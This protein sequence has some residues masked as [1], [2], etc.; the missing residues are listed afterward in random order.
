MNARHEFVMRA[1]EPDANL[2][3]LCRAAGISRKTAYKW[4]LRFRERGMVGLE[5]MSRRPRGSSLRATGEVVMQVLELRGAHPRWGPKKLRVVIARGLAVEDVPS[6]RTIAR[7]LERAGEVRARRRPPT[8]N[9]ASKDAP[10]V[11]ANAPNA[12]WTVDFKG[13]WNAKDGAKCEP[14]TVR[15]AFSRYVLKAK[16][17]TQTGTEPVRAEFTELFERR[18]TPLAIQVDNGPPFGSTQARCG[19]TTLSAWWVA[20]GIR[21]I[22]GRPAHPQDNGAHE[23]MHLDMRYEVED[24][25]ADNLERQQA[26][27]DKW[28][29]EFN[30]VRP[31]EAI[32]LK[33]PS[34]LY[35]SSPRRY[36]GPRK[37]RYPTTMCTRKVTESGRV[38]Y[39]GKLL[40]IGQGFRGYEIGMESLDDPTIVRV[41]FYE[42][43]LGVFQLPV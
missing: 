31:H 37:A 26:E 5:D 30:Y 9:A 17:M 27:M 10:N 13:W 14:L 11:G 28:V 1:M 36:S 19:M 16:L 12:L 29:H 39:R 42:L 22:R 3:E 18:G 35:S 25:S 6:E 21:V 15:D 33:V 23:R 20:T 40:R 43:D 7:I 41:Q 34:D 38:R 4:L 2:A 24:M 8:R 32:E